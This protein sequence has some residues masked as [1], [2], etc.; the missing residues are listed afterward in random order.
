M[1][2]A[3]PAVDAVAT[4]VPQDDEQKRRGRPPKGTLSIKQDDKEDA[5]TESAFSDDDFKIED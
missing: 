4:D 1:A 5:E 2:K 3:A